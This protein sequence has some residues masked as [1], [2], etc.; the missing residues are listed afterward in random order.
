[1]YNVLI[2]K[3]KLDPQCIPDCILR[4]HRNQ[5]KK[6]PQDSDSCSFCF[7]L[8]F[9]SCYH[10]F[11]FKNFNPCFK[12]PCFNALFH[13]PPQKWQVFGC[14]CHIFMAYYN[15]ICLHFLACF[16]YCHPLINQ[17]ICIYFASTCL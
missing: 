4:I 5:S 16:Q 15:L 8:F 2:D 17:R 7:L 9:S 3:I 1:M 13:L 6:L 11:S 10:L 12:N 14:K